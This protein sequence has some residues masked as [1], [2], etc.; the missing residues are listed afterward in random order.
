MTLFGTQAY[1]YDVLETPFTYGDISAAEDF[2]AKHGEPFNKE[3]WKYIKDKH[4]GF[5]PVMIEA[6]PEGT[7]VPL[8]IPLVQVRS[9]DDN[10]PWITSYIETSLL[11]NIWY[12]STVATYSRNVK[13][14]LK[15]YLDKTSD[16]PAGAIAFML[17]DFGARGVSSYES[18]ALG[19]CAHL[20]NFMGT[21]TLAAIECAR[22]WYGAD[23]P[24][25]SVPAAEHS[26]ITSWGPEHEVEAYANM[27]DQFDREGGITSIV[28]DSYDYWNAIDNIYGGTLKDKVL[29]MKGRLVI[30]PDSGNPVDVVSKSVE[31]LCDAFGFTVNS[32]GFKVIKANVRVL[33]GDGVN[34][35]SIDE[36]LNRLHNLGYS[37]ENVVFGMGGALLQDHTR[38]DLRFAMKANAIYIDGEWHD[39]WKKPATDPTKNSKAGIQTVH[40]TAEKGWYSIKAGTPQPWAD[41][42]VNRLQTIVYN[43]ELVTETNL[44]E[45]RA[46]AAL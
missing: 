21:D 43:G 29:A 39:V 15:F 16:D 45:I 24:A 28:S 30:R 19:G 18:A 31:K 22:D 7:T 14:V 3:G 26:T 34:I 6:L 20:I 5:L 36:I 11:R 33:Q 42:D 9:T 2:L 1:F 46:R 41:D 12:G 4:G 40:C 10:T 38:D 32:K 27:I 23:M 25:F 35:N 17:H 37:A 44:E 13:K 8:G